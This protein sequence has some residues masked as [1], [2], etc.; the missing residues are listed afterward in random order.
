MGADHLGSS[1]GRRFGGRPTISSLAAPPTSAPD[2]DL[3]RDRPVLV[4]GGTGFLGSHLTRLLVDAGAA[5]VVLRRDRV[6]PS[7]V[8]RAW[9]DRVT[10][11]EGAV[12][13]QAVIERAL[14]EHEIV[15][16]FHLA[17]QT[18]VGVANA[19]AVSTFEANI[20]GT[21]ALLEAVRRSP[22]VAQV[23]TAS[24][25]K[26]YGAQPVLPYTEDMPLLATHPYDVS[27]ACSDLIAASYHQTFGVPVA[28]T[29][30][31]NFFGPGDR[32]WERLIPGTMRAILR[33]RSPVIRSDGTLVRDYLYVVDGALAYLRLAECMAADPTLA[34][35][36]FNFSTETPLSVLD[37]VARIQTAA[38][39]DLPLDVRGGAAHEIPAQH[40]SAEKARQVL[41]WE[42]SRTVDE[43]LVETVAWYRDELSG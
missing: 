11:V 32:N 39:S 33:G 40:L 27:K 12:E 35:E 14:G 37:L 41:G 19:N 24:S 25:D 6:P 2:P 36:A 8:E 17:A 9:S 5:V 20:T 31:G 34:G 15:T 13:D 30:C 3:W 1:F 38:G 18:Q 26:A 10:W 4:T 23:V 42:P 29:R 16:V 21:W 7:S 22:G 28:I 43:A